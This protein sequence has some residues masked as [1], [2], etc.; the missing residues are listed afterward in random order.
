MFNVDG[1]MQSVFHLKK[2][3]QVSATVI[4]DTPE[5]VESSARAISGQAPPPPPETPQP[6]GAL[7]IEDPAPPPAPAPAEVAE[8]TLP[9]TGSVLPLVGVLGLLLICASLGLRSLRP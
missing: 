9:K 3:M 2:G 4:T 7:L 8:N 1:Q 5:V 6:V